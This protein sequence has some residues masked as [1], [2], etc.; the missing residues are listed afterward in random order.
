MAAVIFNGCKSETNPLPSPTVDYTTTYS[1]ARTWLSDRAPA[2]QNFQI[3][4]NSPSTII[5]ANRYSYTI[6][7]RSLFLNSAPVNGMVDV[8]I[9]EFVS[10]ADMIFSGVTTM[11]GNDPLVSGGMFKIDVSQNG[12]PVTL[13][14]NILVT[15]PTK[16]PDG[17]M[18]VFQGEDILNPDGG[19]G[20]N[21]TLD[22]TSQISIVQDTSS[23]DSFRYIL[24]L[25]FLSW[26]NLDKYYNATSGT[27][28][29]LQ[30]PEYC[31]NENT[32]VYM[33][34]D[35]NSVVMLFGDKGKKE[36]NSGN[37]NLPVGWDI[38]LLAVCIQDKELQYSI[39]DS[40]ITD[41]HMETVSKLTPITE[42]DLEALIR[43]L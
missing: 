31:T 17:Q 10:K 34:F 20:V 5:S 35:E 8:E 28:V 36:F 16:T 32:T 11:A 12:V 41:P 26:C 24:N 43:S 40:K 18:R 14:G 27:P 6:S 21:W 29:R 9:S 33:L 2:V 4:P 19:A 7:P 39:I 38:K 15:I 22:S 42:E 13:N 3:D 25:N 23:R 30:L 1:N 37:Y